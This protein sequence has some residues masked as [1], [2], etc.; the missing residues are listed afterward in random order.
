MDG[1]V[2]VLVKKGKNDK[3]IYVNNASLKEP[4]SYFGGSKHLSTHLLSQS[5][6]LLCVDT[7]RFVY[8]GAGV[9]QCNSPCLH[10]VRLLS[11]IA[12]MDNSQVVGGRVP[13]FPESMSQRATAGG[14][15]PQNLN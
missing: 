13:V 4:V 3:M 14:C 15:H 2:Y 5:R 9:Y 1:S 12:L 10:A 8:A 7:K 11:P 6:L